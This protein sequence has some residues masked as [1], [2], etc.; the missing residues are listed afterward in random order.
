MSL[1]SRTLSAHA[2]NWNHLFAAATGAAAA[3]FK[4]EIT[5]QIDGSIEFFRT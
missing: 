2:S 3:G 4:S 5:Y 1:Q